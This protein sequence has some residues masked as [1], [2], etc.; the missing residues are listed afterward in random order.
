LYLFHKKLGLN[1]N[2]KDKRGSTPLHW[3]CYSQ[4][5]VAIAY[6]LA[7]NPDVNARDKDGFTPLHLAVK[8]VDIFNSC[9]P[10]RALLIK[11]ARIDI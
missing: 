10:V 7:W 2:K 11:G 6:I 4:S 9:R 5:E 3:A 1:I 8:S